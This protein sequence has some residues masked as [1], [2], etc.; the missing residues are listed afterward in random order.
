MSTTRLRL[1]PAA[2][3][4]LLLTVGLVACSDDGGGEDSAAAD[5]DAPAAEAPSGEPIKI[6]QWTTGEGLGVGSELAAA[7]EA[8]VET[9]NAAGGI[10]DP[11]GG[12]NRPIELL[13][14]EIPLDDAGSE[15]ERCARETIDAEVVA[16]TSKYPGDDD[17][18]KAVTEAG[19]PIVDAFAVSGG[20]DVT[21]ELSFPLS[22][23]GATLSVALGAAL[24]DAGAEKIIPALADSP[25]AREFPDMMSQLLENGEDDLLP[26]VYY[27]LDASADVTSYAAQV[28]EEEPDGVAIVHSADGTARMIRAL[29]E[30]GFTGEIAVGGFNLPQAQVENLGDMADGVIV[31]SNFAAATTEGDE[32]IDRFNEGMDEYAEDAERSEFA[33]ASW[34]S[35]QTIASALEAAETID[36]A[37]VA[38]ALQGLEVTDGGV[39]TFTLGE[40]GLELVPLPRV[41]RDT[42]QFQVITDGE[43]HPIENGEFFRID[44]PSAG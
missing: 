7:A 19:I 38:G 6:M 28:I 34:V 16:V 41:P 22:G 42:V 35:V 36:G 29:R 14:C 15:S 23:G 32:T 10:P 44:D 26:A 11:D 4:A 33:I 12:E 3:L 9:I 1:L 13:S 20:E 25:S 17:A 5:D 21:N 39:P 2:L 30:G 8:A 37:G 40:A 43:V 27:P 31:V 18:V 24:Q